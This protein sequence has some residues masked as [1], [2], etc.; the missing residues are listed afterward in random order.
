[1]LLDGK[2]AVVTGAGSGVGRATALRFA[3]EG[4]RVVCADIS[5][6]RVEETVRLVEKTGGT[7]VA[8]RV[9]VAEESEVVGM[10]DSAVEHFGR[11]DILFNNVG[12]PTPRLGGAL[13]EDHTVAEFDRLVAV[14]LRSV[15]L[16]CKHAVLRFKE[17]G[18]GGVILNTGSVAGLVG[19]GG[20]VYGATKG[21]VHQLT[22]AVAIEGAPFGIRANAL[23]P[24]AMPQTNFFAAGGLGQGAELSEEAVR[25]A[26][27]Q[28]PLGKPITAEDCAAAAVYLVSESA[29]NVTGVLLP[30]DGGYVAR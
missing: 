26:G 22:R 3:A 10:L 15:F 8:V 1:M 28:H 2:S 30:V 9:D 7:A 18:G 12:I 21:G 27:A 14:N 16:G 4:A 23:C 5:A 29:G 13:L 25:Q 11:L 17:Q 6:E 24:A 19:W 20:A